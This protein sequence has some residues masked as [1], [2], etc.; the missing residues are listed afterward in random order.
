MRG[1][2]SGKADHKEAAKVRG[3]PTRKTETA[4]EQHWKKRMERER[5]RTGEIKKKGE[6]ESERERERE[7][8]LPLAA[9][10]TGK[11]SE[12]RTA[13]RGREKENGAAHGH[14]THIAH[15]C[16]DRN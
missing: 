14:F 1:Q 3:N 11:R 15:I 2:S 7:R 13:V 12:P 10:I 9:K 8:S 16:R 6:R 5:A 4:N